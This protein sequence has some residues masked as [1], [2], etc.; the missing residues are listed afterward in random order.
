MTFSPRLSLFFFFVFS[1]V[2]PPFLILLLL[3]PVRF[4]VCGFS[5]VTMLLPTLFVL[6]FSVSVTAISLHFFFERSYAPFSFPSFPL[7]VGVCDTPIFQAVLRFFFFPPLL[8][9]FAQLSLFLLLFGSGPSLSTCLHWRPC[10]DP[11]F[12]VP[13]GFILCF[14]LPFSYP[15]FISNDSPNFP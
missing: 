6:R 5:P 13:C 12:P 14:L 8:P 1:D 7:K 10:F 9:P 3:T 11:S 4:F 2:V 15:L